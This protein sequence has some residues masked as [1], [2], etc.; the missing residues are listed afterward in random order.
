MFWIKTYITIYVAN[1]SDGMEIIMKKTKNYTINDIATVAGVSK[2]TVSRYINGHTNLMT[3]ET[4]NR[5]KSVI[6]MANYTP[7]EL[8]RN[9]KKNTSNMIGVVLS[10]ISSPFSSS[11]I[12]GIS[13]YLD[14][15]GYIPL[16]TTCN[17]DI[18][19]EQ[20]AISSL[21]SKGVSGILVNTVSYENNYLI[22]QA[23]K[24]LPIVLCDR[25]VKD[26]N[27]NIVTTESDDIMF[28]LI[29]HLKENGYTKIAIFSEKIS[30]NS[31]RIR[32][33]KSF[34]SAMHSIFGSTYQDNVYEIDSSEESSTIDALR[35]FLSTTEQHDIPAVIGANSVSTVL[36]CSAIMKLNLPI[37][38]KIG[39][40]GPEDWGWT[41][42]MNWPNLIHVPVTTFVIHPQIIGRKAAELLISKINNPGSSP[43][44]IIIR[45]SLIIRES[46]NRTKK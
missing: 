11:L 42:A 22:E 26:Y 45:S 9:L 39:V 21:I 18:S 16:I 1:L 38:D 12:I 13:D 46:T 25:Y 31:S 23:A 17:N 8:A 5:I 6:E 36:L 27:F 34:L 33:T 20:H 37:P 35:S 7:N 24:G 4:A 15:R 41:T 29:T 3:A 14:K 19:K 40:C 44:E 2:A 30:N 32:R 28:D 43:E 10:D